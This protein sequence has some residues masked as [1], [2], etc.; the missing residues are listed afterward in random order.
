MA[1]KKKTMVTGAVISVLSKLIHP[2]QSIRDKYTNPANGDRL[3][4]GIVIFQ[5][6]RNIN[7]RDQQA[8]VFRHNDCDEVEL[9]TVKRF[10]LV[11]TE[12]NKDHFFKDNV[13][14][15]DPEPLEVPILTRPPNLCQMMW[16]I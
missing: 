11:E 3:S 10:C 8:I 13:S 7:R 9:Y 15:D 16:P 14:G 4:S 2:S 6:V 5:E 12:G 1:R